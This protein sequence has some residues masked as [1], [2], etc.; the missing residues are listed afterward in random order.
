MNTSGWRNKTLRRTVDLS[1]NNIPWKGP[2]SDAL[3]KFLN[4]EVSEA[5]KRPWHRL[6]R[7]LRLNRISIF[8]EDEKKRQNLSDSEAK[9]LYNLLIKSLDKKLLNSKSIVNY[10][11]EKERI[12]EIKG[13]IMHRNAEGRVL[14]QLVERKT[15]SIT[16]RRPRAASP[17][18]LEQ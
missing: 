15:N 17:T 10:D 8:V 18:A 14:F 13:L 4:A 3:E 1:G 16:F 12:L 6:E 7:G 2:T 9:D 5:Y 11:T